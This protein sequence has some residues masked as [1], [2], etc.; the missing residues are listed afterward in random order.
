MR[1]RSVFS[2]VVL[3]FI[4]ALG[5]SFAE[6]KTPFI[7]E[8][9]S[10]NINLRSDATTSAYLIGILNKGEQVE[11]LQESYDWYKIRLPKI[12]S[13]Y[14]K[15]SLA[16]CINYAQAQAPGVTS[17]SCLTLK[18]L[19]DRVNIR[20]GASE[21]S[22][23]LGI[24]DQNEVI[25]VRAQEGSWYKIEPIANSF[26]WVYKKFVDK[27]KAAS[28]GVVK[29]AQG[30]GSLPLAKE[31]DNIVLIGVVKPYG[32]IFGRTA[33][34]KLITQDNQVYLL[35]GNRAS[36]NSLNQ[37]KVKVIGKKISADKSKVPVVEV[38]IVEVIS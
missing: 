24:A 25:N 13:V 20:A 33:T 21:T 12:V 22:P 8:I 2:I 6:E 15:A 17:E 10:N 4:L 19:K 23:I 9:N 26:G 14:L 38:K 37:Q 3:I 27:P 18:V 7:G 31:D 29:V 34:H 11:V 5:L 35:K 36:L 32:V 30:K 28:A 16:S 1:L